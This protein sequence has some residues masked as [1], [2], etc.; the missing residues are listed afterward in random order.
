M[1][2]QVNKTLGYRASSQLRQLKRDPQK[3]KQIYIQMEGS[4][5]E[6]KFELLGAVRNFQ[7]SN[8]HQTIK[9]I[10]QTVKIKAKKH[11]IAG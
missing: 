1:N 9:P 7:I 10:S 5:E 2:I 6:N 3:Y 8:K 11:A 4:S